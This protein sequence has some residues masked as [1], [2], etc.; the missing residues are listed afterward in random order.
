[1]HRTVNFGNCGM[2][3]IIM[4]NAEFRSSTLAQE[5]TL[6][7]APRGCGGLGSRVNLQAKGGPK[8]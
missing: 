1:M 3:L 2:F 8:P 4:G 5:H 7:T 6:G